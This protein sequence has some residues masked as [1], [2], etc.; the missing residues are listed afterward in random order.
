[1]RI[2]TT[3]KGF[4][5]VRGRDRRESYFSF[6]VDGDSSSWTSKC[7]WEARHF[8]TK[9]EADETLLELL[10]RDKASRVA[11]QLYRDSGGM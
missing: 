5:I 11:R 8:R 4:I 6:F 3:N 2:E 7:P 10:R 1:M 9:K